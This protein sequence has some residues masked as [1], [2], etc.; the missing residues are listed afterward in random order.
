MASP[1]RLH[2]TGLS[3]A[4]SIILDPLVVN[5]VRH[6]NC[7]PAEWVVHRPLRG[8]RVRQGSLRE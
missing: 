6:E 1:P 5:G 2:P 4:E 7:E 8:R 3:E